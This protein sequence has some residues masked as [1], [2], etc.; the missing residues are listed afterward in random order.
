MHLI[1]NYRDVLKKAWS[2]RLILVAGLLSGLEVVLPFFV[3]NVPR[4]LFAVLTMV[5][6][7]GAFFARFI[8]QK[9]LQNGKND[10]PKAP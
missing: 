7:T 6:T 4:G 1:S 5:T 3:S 10:G 9:E 2:V 8:V